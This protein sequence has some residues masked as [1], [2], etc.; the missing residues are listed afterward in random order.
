MAVE[1]YD[2]D[3]SADDEGDD[4]EPDEKVVTRGMAAIGCVRRESRL[5]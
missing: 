1:A 2:G 4:N 3:D 5:F